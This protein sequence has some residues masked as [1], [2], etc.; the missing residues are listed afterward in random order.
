VLNLT[1]AYSQGVRNETKLFE[2]AIEKIEGGIDF[3]RYRGSLENLIDEIELLSTYA[4]L[5]QSGIGSSDKSVSELARQ[6][7]A[8]VSRLQSDELPILREEYKK[9]VKKD[10]VIEGLEINLAVEVGNR[11]SKVINFVCSL[12]GVSGIEGITEK[13]HFRNSGHLKLFRFWAANYRTRIDNVMVISVDLPMVPDAAL[14]G[15]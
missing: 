4:A 13:I 10:Y 7:G 5:A 9:L 14:L 2:D 8:R 3:S 15:I 11:N 6:L 12:C 1:P